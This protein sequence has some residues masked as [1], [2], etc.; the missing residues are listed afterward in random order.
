MKCSKCG[1]DKNE[2]DFPT[3]NKNEIRNRKHYWCSECLKETQ[4][5][6][7]YNAPNG[8]SKMITRL[9]SSSKRLAKERG[10][11]R[12][13]VDIDRKYILELV[14]LQNNKCAVS[15]MNLEWEY[16]SPH[17]VSIDRIDNTKGYTKDNIRLV[18]KQVNYGISSFS[19]DNFYTMCKSV[20][21]HNGLSLCPSG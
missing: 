4:K 12:S 14:E 18:C 8:K 5:T 9:V 21:E 3:D 10:G 17:K 7:P 6:Q 20:V 1:I 19:I 16:N 15:G 11:D 2:E 13:Y